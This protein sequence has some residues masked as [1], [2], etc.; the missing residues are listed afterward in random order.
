MN[1][2]RLDMRG[3][4]KRYANGLLANDGIDLCLARGEIHALIGE[5]GAGKSTL[6]KMLYG[7][8]Q[9][10]AGEIL[11]DGRQVRFDTPAAA[12]RAGIGL[13]PQH[14]QLVPSFSVAR[15]VVLGAEPRRWG[16]LDHR[17]AA[18]A[19]DALARR[20]GLEADPAAL[21]GMLPL[22]AQQR[23]EILKALYR[24]ADLLLLDEPGAVLAPDE[25]AALFEAL[26]ALADDG[27]SVLLITHKIADV[28]EVADR[29]TVLRAGRVVASG[30]SS[31][32]DAAGLAARIVGR[33]LAPPVRPVARA[34]G[35]VRLR[36]RG[37]V[38]ATGAAECLAGVDLDVAA[39]EILGIAGVE[40][41]GQA[42]LARALAR[43][44]D[45]VLVTE[46]R[47]HDGVAPAL[48]IAENA[49]ATRYREAPL[50]RRGWLDLAAIDAATRA[51]ISDYGV[52]AAGPQQ[53]IGALSGGNMQKIVLARALAAQPGVLV[54]C[55]PTRGVDIGAARFLRQRLLALRDAGAAIVLVSGDLDEIL[56][57]SDRVAVM[58]RG[59]IAGHFRGEGLQARLLSGYMTGA[60]RQPQASARLDAPFVDGEAA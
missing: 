31:E 17:A 29:Y 56:E 4:A 40:G 14:V 59:A 50:S 44:P 38:H 47:L 22:G 36:A 58:F 19:V 57:L 35:E 60:R 33:P 21:A 28:L 11:L 32:A 15:N 39:G 6:I 12:I 20:Y 42:L 13:V 48:S 2:P 49:I 46:D 25:T 24:G 8:E 43:E 3:V 51:M 53:P 30:S 41:N 23:V 18:R 5:N 52:A 7:L 16:W 45:V 10:S 26:R 27:M 55:Q 34:P 9:P 37:L 54:A 1:F